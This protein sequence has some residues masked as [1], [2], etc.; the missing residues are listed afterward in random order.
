MS[1]SETPPK[2]AFQVDISEDAIAEALRAVEGGSTT[3]GVENTLE[4]EVEEDVVAAAGE[5]DEALRAELDLKEQLLEESAKRTQQLMQRLQEA[6]DLRLRAVA[7]LE[8][9]KKRA[10][11]ERE[12]LQKFGIEKLL[13]ELIPVLDN[14]DRALEAS[15]GGGDLNS[16]AEGVRMNRRLFEETLGKFGVK[17]FSAVGELFDPRFHEAIQQ[18]ES[19]EHAANVVVREL[20]RGYQLHERLVRPAM[21]VVSSGPGPEAAAAPSGEETQN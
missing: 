9:Y 4:I 2:N 19:T 6:N 8:N 1:Q 10:A 3:T 18:V 12:E 11:R 21:V 17:G 14:F 20:V 7:D 5:G 15:A 16:F 13:S